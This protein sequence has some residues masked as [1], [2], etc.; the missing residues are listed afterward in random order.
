MSDFWSDPSSASILMY[1]NSEGSGETVQM[2]SLAR[3]FAGRL[4]DKY[5]ELAHLIIVI[6]LHLFFLQGTTE[7]KFL[8]V[9]QSVNN[10][11]QH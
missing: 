1:A 9:H 6:L 7:L 3:A 2:R 11:H 8:F 10:S 4:C 5:L